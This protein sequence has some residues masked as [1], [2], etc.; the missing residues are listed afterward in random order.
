MELITSSKSKRD[1]LSIFTKQ[2]V[3][4]LGQ[5]NM[6]SNNF[7]P[8]QFPRQFIFIQPPPEPKRRT[9][10]KSK[11]T[12]DYIEGMNFNNNEHAK[13]NLY[14]TNKRINNYT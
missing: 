9:H 12:I 13:Q 11:M 8:K 14:K 6:S 4:Q 7:L 10:G 5:T 1:L 2:F 3:N